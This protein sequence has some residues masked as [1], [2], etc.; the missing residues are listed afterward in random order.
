M[1]KLTAL[2]L[3]LLL[4]LSVAAASLQTVCASDGAAPDPS[5][6]VT[7]SPED[8]KDPVRPGAPDGVNE[9]PVKEATSE[10]E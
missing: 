8:P 4:C 2:M 6:T 10:V 1:K 7:V 3:A 9:L 5:P